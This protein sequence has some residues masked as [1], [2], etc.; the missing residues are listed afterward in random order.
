M[1]SYPPYSDHDFPARCAAQVKGSA[2]AQLNGPIGALWPAVV[3]GH[4]FQWGC[5][6]DPQ[7]GSGQQRFDSQYWRAN[8]DPSERYVLSVVGSSAYRLKSDGSGFSNLYLA[9][10]WLKTGL[11]AGCVEAA[12]MGGMQASRAISGWPQVIK[13]EDW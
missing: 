5:L 8:V 6:I 13:G 10:D 1:A 9:G 11:D 2:I 3:T 4:G 7:G 12:V